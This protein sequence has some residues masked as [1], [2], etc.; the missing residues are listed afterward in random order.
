MSALPTI[1]VP[2][3][4]RLPD[5]NQWENRFEVRSESSSNLYTIAQN[6]R[7]RFWGCSCRGWI[8][9]KKCK[10][11]AAVGLPPHQKPHEAQLTQ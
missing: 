6:K 9:R 7:G 1:Y 10:H 11:L 8:R 3:S 2:H 4:M 5:N